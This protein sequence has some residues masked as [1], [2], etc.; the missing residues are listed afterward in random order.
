MRRVG[1]IGCGS[2]GSEVA[3]AIDSGLVEAKLV[4]LFDLVPERCLE[5]A[6]E[7]RGKPLACRDFDCFASQDLDIAVEA[8]SQSA[9]RSYAI[10]LLERGVDLVVLSVGALLDGELLERVRRAAKS[11][12]AR[13]YVPSGAICG[14]DAAKALSLVG[15]SR[16]KLTT[17][18]SP[19][20]IDRSSLERLGHGAESL[21]SETLVF[22]GPAEEAVRLLPFNVNVAATLR[23]ATNS[24]VEVEFVADPR[25]DANVHEIVLESSASRVRIVVENKPH[26]RNPKTS[27]LAAL[28]AIALLKRLVEGGVVVGT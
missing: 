27:Y 14:V 24:D 6:R 4:A 16:V 7:L 28:S 18:K 12:G 2:I 21:S 8:A 26:P 9:V 10:P 11:S 19:K 23:L 3:R 1:I 15:L 13:V 22:R 20:S 17:R 5:L 25:V